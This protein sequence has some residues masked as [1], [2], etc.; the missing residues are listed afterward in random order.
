MNY[1]ARCI[2]E[3]LIPSLIPRMNYETRSILA[4]AFCGKVVQQILVISPSFSSS[5][6]AIAVFTVSLESSQLV[7]NFL[8]IKRGTKLVT[9]NFTSASGSK[10]AMTL[11][12]V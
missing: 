2:L 9:M 10:N 5:Q 1:E 4:T 8:D 7:G 11:S 12:W 6:G 3:A